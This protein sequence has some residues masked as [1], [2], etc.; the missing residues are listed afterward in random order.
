MNISS[1]IKWLYFT[2]VDVLNDS[3][4]WGFWNS[5]SV[6]S[7][8]N[9]HDFLQSIHHLYHLLTQYSVSLSEAL[10]RP[11]E[12]NSWFSRFN[13]TSSLKIS[14][15]RNNGQN[16]SMPITYLLNACS[17]FSRTELASYIWIHRTHS[18]APF[19]RYKKALE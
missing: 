5:S 3:G 13:I 14:I 11:L 10:S 16:S 15:R 17:P 6:A 19:D 2:D 12:P 18:V 7:A 8:M 1:D 4:L 9:L